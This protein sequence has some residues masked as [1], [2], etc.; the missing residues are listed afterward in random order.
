MHLWD[1]EIPTEIGNIYGTYIQ[2]P[3]RQR[4]AKQNLKQTGC[5]GDEWV[6]GLEWLKKKRA[7]ND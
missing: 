1:I 6:H 3:S 2:Y 7:L 4:K 5:E